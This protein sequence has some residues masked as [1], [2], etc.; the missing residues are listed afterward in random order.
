MNRIFNLDHARKYGCRTLGGWEAKVMNYE[1]SNRDYPLL[2]VIKDRF[3]VERPFAYTR[4]GR[5]TINDDDD[6]F[7]CLTTDL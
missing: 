5:Y 2:V 4:D 6:H 3:G 1:L 7:R